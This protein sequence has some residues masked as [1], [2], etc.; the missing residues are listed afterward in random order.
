MT[1][2]AASVIQYPLPSG[3][4]AMATTGAVGPTVSGAT[5]SASPFVAGLPVPSTT[6]TVKDEGPGTVGMPD[7]TPVDPR[8]S[9]AG[10]DPPTTD[11]RTAPVAPVTARVTA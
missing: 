3:A 10:S 1:V 11:H 9:P 6:R 4:P 5:S 7:S 8:L 2:P